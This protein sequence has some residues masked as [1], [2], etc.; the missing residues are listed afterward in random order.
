MT[1]PAAVTLERESRTSCWVEEKH[2]SKT[3]PHFWS[4][5]SFSVPWDKSILCSWRIS[6]GEGVP[7]PSLGN[8]E[9]GLWAPS[10][11]RR[12]MVTRLNSAF[13]F[14]IGNVFNSPLFMSLKKGEWRKRP[15]GNLLTKAQAAQ[16][17]RLYSFQVSFQP[18]SRHLRVGA[19][20]LH[21]DLPAT[22]L[23]LIQPSVI[24]SHR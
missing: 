2:P 12:Q 23:S 8:R 17:S 3:G 9:P 16:K 19:L 7:A 15:T 24:P 13:H 4:G 14:N 11:E 21:H 1:N 5:V 10:L 6:N 22:P 18:A 20:P